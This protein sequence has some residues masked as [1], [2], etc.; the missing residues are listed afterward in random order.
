MKKLKRNK[1]IDKTQQHSSEG[2]ELLIRLQGTKAISLKREQKTCRLV[3]TLSI[4][5][6]SR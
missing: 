5:R 6:H 2:A 4:K 3:I 1:D